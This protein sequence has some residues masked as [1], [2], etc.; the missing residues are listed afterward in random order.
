MKLKNNYIFP[1]WIAMGMKKVDQRT[2]YEA[3]LLSTFLLMLG[4]IATGIYMIAYGNF[5]LFFKIM[6]GINCFAAFIFMS[7]ALTTTYQQYVSYMEAIEMFMPS[8]SEF[9]EKEREIIKEL[10]ENKNGRE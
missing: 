10:E 8:S 9:S 1:N 5:T 3:T 6:M 2:Q 4:I 7:S